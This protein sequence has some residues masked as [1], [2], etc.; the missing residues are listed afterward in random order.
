MTTLYIAVSTG[1][2]LMLRLIISY[3]GFN[4][5][6]EFL[7]FKQDYIH[8]PIWYYSFYIHVFSSTICLVAGLTQFSK[9]LLKNSPKT[10]KIVG[11]IYAYNILVINFPVGIIMAVYANGLWPTK[12]AFIILDVL[13]FWFTLKAVLDIKKGNVLSHK[14]N[15]IRSFALTF[16]AVTL[17]SWNVILSSLVD[18]DPLTLYMINGWLGWVPNLIVAEV[19]N[20]KLN[21][22]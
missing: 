8:I 5:N 3:F 6:V 7:Q 16:S 15:M 14:K 20:L 11:R 17:R 18:F 19:Y 1:L 21:K 4:S 12:T 9:T 22:R 13:W 2:F 10:H